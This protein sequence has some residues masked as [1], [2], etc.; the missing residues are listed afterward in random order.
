MAFTTR[1]RLRCSELAT[2]R[3]RRHAR[4]CTRVAHCGHKLVFRNVNWKPALFKLNA[5][6]CCAAALDANVLVNDRALANHNVHKLWLERELANVARNVRQ[7]FCCNFSS[8]NYVSMAMV[9]P[10]Q[11]YTIGDPG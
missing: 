10:A 3:S 4:A 5:N 1:S 9:L 7:D 11:Q 2:A 6:A 8:V